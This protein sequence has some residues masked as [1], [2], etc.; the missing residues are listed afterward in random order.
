MERSDIPSGSTIGPMTAARLGVATVDAG[1][2]A[3]A[4]H[5]ARELGGADDPQYFI[6]A[7]NSFLAR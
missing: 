7:L 3:L 1:M 2:A 6:R 4:M 5:S